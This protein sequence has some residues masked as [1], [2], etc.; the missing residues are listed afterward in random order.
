[1]PV[2]VRLYILQAA[3]G[4]ALSAVM[5]GGLLV[6]NVANLG[7]LVTTSDVGVVA[8][9]MLWVFNGI[10]LGAVQFGIRIMLMAEDDGGS[11]GRGLGQTL[12]PVAVAVRADAGR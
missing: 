9:L 11:A 2:L 12:R 3:I 4:F 6:I 10:V 8:L 1:M 5:V 7:H